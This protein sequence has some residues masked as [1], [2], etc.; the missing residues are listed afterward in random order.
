MNKAAARELLRQ[1]DF[2]GLFL[3]ELG[4][5]DHEGSLPLKVGDETIT[6]T[7]VAEKR[8]MAAYLCALPGQDRSFDYQTRCKI[9]IQLA[10]SAR[11]HLITKL[12]II[13]WTQPA[14]FVSGA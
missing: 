3:N 2:K 8:G 11:E 13:I 9:E 1:F 4:W 5:D 6:F 12:P 7:A 14:Y 10:K